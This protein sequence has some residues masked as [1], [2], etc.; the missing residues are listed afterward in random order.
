MSALVAEDTEKEDPGNYQPV[1]LTS[2]PR[3][4]MTEKFQKENL[5]PG[6]AAL[7]VLCPVLGLTDRGS[8]LLVTV[9]WKARNMIR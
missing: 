8:K 2:I 3:K 4:V 1:N 9:Q 7:E 6:E 5:Y